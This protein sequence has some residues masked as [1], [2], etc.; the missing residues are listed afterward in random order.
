[1]AGVAPHLSIRSYRQHP[2]DHIL[3]GGGF[4]VLKDEYAHSSLRLRTRPAFGLVISLWHARAKNVS[5]FPS[6]RSG[7]QIARQK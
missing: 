7:L 2:S 6:S 4:G 3:A 1:M 5:C